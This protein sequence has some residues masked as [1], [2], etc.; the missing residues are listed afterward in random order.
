[1][2]DD[3]DGF[4]NSNGEAIVRNIPVLVFSFIS[5]E[6][7]YYLRCFSVQTASGTHSGYPVSTISAGQQCATQKAL[8]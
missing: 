2:N 4:L 8:R 6:S 7:G 1:M 5:F 3:S